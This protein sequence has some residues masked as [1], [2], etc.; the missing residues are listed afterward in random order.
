MLKTVPK[1]DTGSGLSSELSPLARGKK[2]KIT[3]TKDAKMIIA[4]GSAMETLTRTTITKEGGG[5]QVK[6]INCS[7]DGVSPE[8]RGD[9]ST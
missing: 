3:T 4:R 2:N 8:V 1:E 5:L 7:A 9:I 6:E